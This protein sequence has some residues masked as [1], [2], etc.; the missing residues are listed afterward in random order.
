VITCLSVIEHGVDVSRF[1]WEAQR[2]LRP[3]GFLIIS[4][5]YWTEP[6]IT[7]GKTAYGAEIKIFTPHGIQSILTEATSI[8]LAPIGEID[9]STRDKAVHWARVRLDFTFILFAL[10]KVR[11]EP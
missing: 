6:L 11:K 2:I 10:T 5:D 9:Y 3:G 8:G 4:T 7:T 1:L